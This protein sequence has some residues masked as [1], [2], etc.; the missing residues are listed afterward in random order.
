MHDTG[1]IEPA[2]KMSDDPAVLLSEEEEEDDEFDSDDVESVPELEEKLSKW[3]NYIH[4]WQDR[5]VSLRNG[6]LSYFK[7]HTDIHL[8][9]RGSISLARA[10]IEVRP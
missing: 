9:C 7:A 6:T 10:E 1:R 2:R 8:G 4:G 3:T 5:W